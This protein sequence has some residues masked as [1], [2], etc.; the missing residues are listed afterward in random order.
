MDI[1][2]YQRLSAETDQ[3][4]D[5]ENAIVVP[6]LGLAGETG[7]L[8]SSYKKRLR[9][10][11]AHEAFEANVA[12]DVGDVLWYLANIATKLK[13]KLSDVAARNL[14]KTR[15]RFGSPT[16]GG[17]AFDDDAPDA[18]RLPRVFEITFEERT[19]DGK[20]VLLLFL[21]G[22]NV[23]DA[24][25]DNAYLPDGY[26]FHDAFHLA[27]AT[28]LDWSPVTRF[29]L[30]RKR[31][32]DPSKDEVEDGGRAR[33]FEEAIAAL[34]FDRAR[35]TGFFEGVE[36]LDYD[37]LATARRLVAH[38]EVGV[39][40]AA[41]WERAILEG[42]RIWRTLRTNNGGRVRYNRVLRT[43]EYLGH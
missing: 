13:L 32:S 14:V 29:V 11:P 34:A 43:S 26:R 28:Y 22:Q 24:L 27:Y 25:T 35:E 15:G 21:D 3:V 23:G 42:F 8:L 4:S 36:R 39:R 19:Q 12:E 7:T 10:G 2:E 31:R 40:S 18:E 33:V 38:Q 6:L 20:D 37:L 16:P 9:D 1:D 30:K 5:G 17:R 41:D